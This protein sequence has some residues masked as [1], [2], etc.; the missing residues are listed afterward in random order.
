VGRLGVVAVPG[1][2]W[3]AYSLPA[4]SLLAVS[5]FVA[6]ARHRLD[7]STGDTPAPAHAQLIKPVKAHP[8]ATHAARSAYVVKAGDT[9]A[10]IA[11]QTGLTEAALVTLN[12]SVTPTAL[13]IGEKI[14]L[15]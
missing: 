1:R 5:V 3:R 6:L 11:A 7:H 2:G 13:F 4:A 10:S 15:R 12:P 9:L 8:A 14:R